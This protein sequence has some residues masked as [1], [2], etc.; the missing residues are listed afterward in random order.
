MDG[1]LSAGNAPARRARVT[2]AD[3][4]WI[5]LRA[6]LAFGGGLGILA[7]LEDELV[8]RRKALSRADFLSFYGIAR[9]VP[10]GTMSALAA[11]YGYRFGG[12]WGSAIALAAL[13]LPAFVITVLLTALY[14]V[15]RAMDLLPWLEVSVL[16][17]ALALILAAAIRLGREVFRPSVELLLALAAFAAVAFLGVSPAVALLAGGLLGL[18]LFRAAPAPSE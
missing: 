16:P 18:L 2:H 9:L 3:V 17:A 10:S 14:Q 4:F 5:F 12:V 11:G 8:T 1:D 13:V 7:A 15:F 6:G